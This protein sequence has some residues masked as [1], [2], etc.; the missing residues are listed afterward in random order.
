M[1]LWNK[2]LLGLIFV[3]SLGFFYTAAR[4]LKTQKSWR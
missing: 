3:A 1:S 2:I 4:T